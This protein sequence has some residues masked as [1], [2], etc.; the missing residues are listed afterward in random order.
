[1]FTLCRSFW[2][3]IGCHLHNL[4]KSLEQVLF[5]VIFAIE[6]N[7]AQLPNKVAIESLE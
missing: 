6:F 4:A 2:K 3:T 1:M 5:P 7:T